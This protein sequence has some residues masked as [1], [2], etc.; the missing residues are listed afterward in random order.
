MKSRF[1]DCCDL[2]A[3][4]PPERFDVPHVAE[5]LLK[6]AGLPPIPIPDLGPSLP[7]RFAHVSPPRFVDAQGLVHDGLSPDQMREQRAAARKA[8]GVPGVHLDLKSIAGAG[9]LLRALKKETANPPAEIQAVVRKLIPP[10]GPDRVPLRDLADHA[11]LNYL[12]AMAR[13]FRGQGA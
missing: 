3:R 8:Y 10:G 1:V 9:D 7:W 5:F 4:V 12:R 2:V 13:S 11:P 6:V